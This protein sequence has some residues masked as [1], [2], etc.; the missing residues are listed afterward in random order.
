[1]ISSNA[2]KFFGHLTVSAIIFI[3]AAV[4]GSSINASAQTTGDV[5][6]LVDSLSGGK[7]Q[8]ETQAAPPFVVGDF[9]GD[10][11]EDAAVI[12]SL[13]DSAANVGK[14]V[15]IEYPYATAWG[16]KVKTEDLALFIIHGKGKGWQTEQ[17]SSFLM[18]GENSVLIFQK[19]RLGSDL[20]Q[21]MEV[22]KDKRGK[23]SVVF[24]TEAS[25]G[26]LKWNGKKYTWTESQP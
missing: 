4:F 23:S 8:V 13:K 3:A 17:K 16:K 1:M 15:K 18:L 7:L 2:K 21:A 5:E 26:T 24:I 6:K 25:D 14:S 19:S 9:N 20:T 10:K 11:I 12:V 22:K